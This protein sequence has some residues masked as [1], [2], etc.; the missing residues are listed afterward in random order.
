M[1]GVDHSAPPRPKSHSDA[2]LQRGDRRRGRVVGRHGFR[3]RGSP[4][5]VTRRGHLKELVALFGFLVV[6]Y[7]LPLFNLT[8]VSGSGIS[9]GSL[10]FYPVGIYV[11]MALGLDV[12]VGRAG[13]TVL[14]YAALFAGGAY[15]TALLSTKDGWTYWDT[16]PVAIAVGL[17]AGCAL[18]LVS[19]RVQGHYLA[20]VTLGAGLIVQDVLSNVQGLGGTLGVAS[21]PHPSSVLGL[22]F[23]VLDIRSYD[24]LVLTAIV[25]TAGIVW[26]ASRGRAGRAWAAIRE[27]EMA[28]AL[29]GV[30]VGLWK[31]AAFGLGG[32]IAGLAGSLYAG[33]VGYI[34]PAS[35]T[36]SLSVLVLAAVVLVG[37]GRLWSV[38]AGA[39]VVAYLPERFTVINN[40]N[41]MVFGLVL[42][43]V[44]VFQP[45][46]LAGPLRALWTG[47]WKRVLGTEST[48]PVVEPAKELDVSERSKLLHPATNVE[49]EVESGLRIRGLDMRFGGL[50]VVRALDLDV[51]TGEV[52]SLIGPNGAGKTTVINL[53]SGVYEP[54]DGSIAI[55][56]RSLVGRAPEY[57]ARH[58]VARTFQNIRLFRSL[59]VLENVLVAAESGLMAAL[60]GGAV[61]TRGTRQWAMECLGMVGLAD[62]ASRFA[63][64]LSYGE[65]RRLELARGLALAP[66]VL[67]VDEPAA[68]S[69][70][71]EKAALGVLL[72]RIAAQGHA[73]LLVEHDMRLVMGISHR[74]VVMNF[75]EKIA[76]GTPD[77]VRH[78]P[79]VIDAY[80]GRSVGAS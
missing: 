76:E 71:T 44:M 11:L 28:A 16:L 51:P 19:L 3:E 34:D 64:T 70:P 30:R 21:I 13:Q 68:G 7:V 57:R 49:S 61:A 24:W 27:D 74:V 69:T 40:W 53:V 54:R 67:L 14:C 4:P 56:G 9:F 80:L 25:C 63:S 78:E 1:K 72:Q 55:A 47:R 75:G 20:I 33:Q 23:T 35:F 48:E 32:A 50:Q 62:R 31:I 41:T 37:K 17:C 8:I 52:T 6:V 43:C 5:V 26:L 39:V 2:A 18:S 58:G 60:D 36:L 15:A 38:I 42:A 59:T 73:V 65:Q 45:D 79:A 77:E 22:S 46:G 10:L 12:M 29:T 66:V